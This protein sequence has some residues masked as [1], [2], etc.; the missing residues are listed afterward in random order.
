MD[1]RVGTKIGFH[2]AAQQR[3]ACAAAMHKMHGLSH[4]FFIKIERR[5]PKMGVEMPTEFE[6]K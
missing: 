6:P 3:A 2:A 1:N 5:R 4:C